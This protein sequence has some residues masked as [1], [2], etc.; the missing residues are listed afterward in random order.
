M[1]PAGAASS[2]SRP[3]VVVCPGNGCANIRR[4]NWYGDL[5][6]Q[7]NDRGIPCVCE[8]FPDPKRARRDQ[9]IPHIR[10]LVQE[11]AT[12]DNVILVGH[13]SGAQAALRYAELYPVSATVLVA[14]TYSDLGDS[15]ERASGYYPQ[16][17]N[18]KGTN[19]YLFEAMKANCPIWHQFHSDNDPF[20]PLHE[21]E[22][23]RDGL[24]LSEDDTYHMLAGRSH[25]FKPF[26]EL[27]AVIESLC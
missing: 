9:W 8:N 10:K 19:P 24:G 1:K 6:E 20:I 16:S 11:H 22:R 17:N 25:F 3:T 4:S 18:G 7:L 27:L 23:V 21:A 2:S 12:A 15:G 26:P 14:A 5:F 13:S